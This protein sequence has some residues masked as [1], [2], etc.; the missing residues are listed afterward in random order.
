MRKTLVIIVTYNGMQ[1]IERCVS[2][3]ADSSIPA[4][5]FVVDN[6]STDGTVDYLKGRADV[7]L[8]CNTENSGFGAANNI[9]LRKALADGYDFAYLLNQDA[10]LEADTLEKLIAASTE[11][12][13]IL[14]PLQRDAKGYLDKNF[15]R[16]CGKVLNSSNKSSTDPVE[17]KFVMAAH[18]LLTR[19]AI[20]TVGGFSPAFTQYGE[21]DNWIDRAHYFGF[22]VGVVPCASAV[23]DRATRK[24]SKESRMKLK[25][26]APVVKL[27]NPG[28]CWAFRIFAEP[29][30]LLIMS[31]KN[32]SVIPLIFIPSLIHKY[33]GLSLLRKAS[34]SHKAFL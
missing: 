15:E 32:L 24:P 22:K 4:D 2:S 34:K 9:G 27:S 25:C 11:Q 30:E 14:S 5:I 29:A 17:V 21:D 31:I 6:G 28:N 16:K 18:W 12:Y 33:K 8:L 20:E 7:E 13:A 3:I 23:H 1:W 26:V 19:K 10:W